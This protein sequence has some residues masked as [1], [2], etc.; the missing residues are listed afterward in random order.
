[1]T[2]MSKL[3]RFIAAIQGQEVDRLPITTWVHFASEHLEPEITAV[4]HR[5]FYQAYDWDWIKVMNDYRY[6]LP[7]IFQ[8]TNEAELAVIKPL[9]LKSPNFA[10]QLEVLTLLRKSVGNDVAMVETLFDPL[11]TL[12][13]AAGQS[14]Y[15][16]VFNH[17]DLGKT[18]LEGVTRSLVAYVEAIKAR[19]VNGLFLSVNGAVDPQKGG[20]SEQCFMDFVA[21]YCQQILQAAEGMVRIVH[22]HGYDL[23]F[24]RVLEWPTEAYSWSHHHTR[25]SLAEARQMTSAALLGGIDEV[26]ITR[27]SAGEVQAGLEQAVQE[28][29][30]RKL[31]L[32][33]GC[34]IPPDSPQRLL[35]AVR[36][37]AQTF[38]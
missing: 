17:P 14:V 11:Q 30:S 13:R 19:G 4:L 37:T 33:P 38:H 20:L 3:E 8:I 31:L 9:S 10:N 18:V 22:V 35:Q 6:P 16:P 28:A 23:A 26:A 27:Q 34:T 1:M 15:Q 7:G 5:R 24:E 12:V 29:G 32:A 25:P 36:K 21:P 2:S